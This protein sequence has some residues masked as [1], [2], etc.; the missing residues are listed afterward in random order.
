M[1]CNYMIISIKP[2][3]NY[4]IIVVSHCIYRYLNR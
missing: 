1:V 3:L 4:V 2:F